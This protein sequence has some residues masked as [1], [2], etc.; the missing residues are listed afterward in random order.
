MTKHNWSVYSL[1]VSLI[2]VSGLNLLWLRFPGR[3]HLAVLVLVNLIGGLVFLW[4]L[5]C[6]A[7]LAVRKGRQSSMSMPGRPLLSLGLSLLI[8]NAVALYI[9]KLQLCFLIVVVNIA[10]PVAWYLG[11]Q[12]MLR[13]T[14]RRVG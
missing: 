12:V 13:Y 1:F 3:I 5:F 14:G 4:S 10:V 9:C 8:A 7:L 2:V 11:R 6:V